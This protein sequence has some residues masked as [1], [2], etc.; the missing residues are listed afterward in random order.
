MQISLSSFADAYE[1][2]LP[3]LQKH[4][5][6][7]AFGPW[8]DVELDADTETY[9]ILEQEGLLRTVVARDDEDK[10]IGYL[11]VICGNM[12][13]HKSL[14]KAVSDV[15]YVSPEYRKAGIAA[16]MIKV[17]ME[18]CKDHGISFFSIGVNINLDFSKMLEEN[19]AV[20][21]EKQYTWR[22]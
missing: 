20:L 15:I 12:N 7:I 3:M 2:A 21:T 19:G 10:M 9:L 11:M 14:W 13:H 5:K 17:M 16:Q 22:L 4:R 18:D 8:D 6:E 1:E